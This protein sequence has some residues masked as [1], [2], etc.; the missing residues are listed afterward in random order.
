MDI[1]DGEQFS[2][3]RRVI[4]DFTFDGSSSNAPAVSLTLKARNAPGGNYLQTQSKDT[5]RTATTPVEQF[6]N[7]LDLLR[8]V[9]ILQPLECVGRLVHPEL[10]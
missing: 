3:I 2:L 9:L 1:A 5:T 4:P 10:I 7:I 8:C 6:T